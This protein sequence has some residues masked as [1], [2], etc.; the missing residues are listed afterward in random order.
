MYAVRATTKSFILNH[1]ILMHITFLF[2]WMNCASLFPQHTND[3]TL[4]HLFKD[5]SIIKEQF[6]GFEFENIVFFY[7][8]KDTTDH[9][10]NMINHN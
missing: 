6:V 7:D 1:Y 2:C 4:Y 5:F 10:N 9:I 3:G 8:L